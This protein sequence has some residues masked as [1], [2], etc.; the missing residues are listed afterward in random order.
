MWFPKNAILGIIPFL[1]LSTEKSST[2]VAA[3]FSST[4]DTTKNYIPTISKLTPS[5]TFVSSS[6]I[7]VNTAGDGFGTSN[8]KQNS[9]KKKRGG[10]MSRKKPSSSKTSTATTS[11]NIIENPFKKTEVNDY[12]DNTIDVSDTTESSLSEHGGSQIYSKPALYD[13]AFGYRNFEEEVRFLI[14]AHTKFSEDGKAPESI[15]ELAAGPARHSLTALT[16][17]SSSIRKCHAVDISKEMAEYSKE[18]AKLDYNVGDESFQYSSLDMRDDLSSLFEGEENKVDSAW[19]LLGSMQHLLTTQDVLNT[20]SSVGSVVKKGGTLILELPHPRELFQL[21]ECTQNGWEIPLAGEGE[22][23]EEEED[24]GELKII[25]GDTDDEFDPIS[26]IRQF[27]VSLTLYGTQ[28]NIMQEVKEVV[29]MRLFTTQEIEALAVASQSWSLEKLYG[30]LDP[31]EVDVN[32]E[33]A[34]FRLICVLKHI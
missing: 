4:C 34:A 10:A 24:A 22:G 9:N 23:E 29:P 17:F 6:K 2:A 7:F 14:D 5:R 21:M 20:F 18:I 1:I 25:W 13:L 30:A 11:T 15:L 3:F 26:Q 32:D 31:E 28:N 33:D 19:M 12:G 8:K 16:E 27:T